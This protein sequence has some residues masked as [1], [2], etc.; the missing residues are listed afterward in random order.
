MLSWDR[1]VDDWRPAPEVVLEVVRRKREASGNETKKEDVV[2]IV[3]RI[4]H[5]I[6]ICAMF[7]VFTNGRPFVNLATRFHPLRDVAF[8]FI[9]EYLL[10]PLWKLSHT[11]SLSVT[12]QLGP[13]R[14]EG[15]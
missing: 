3:E 4:I 12:H 11:T 14:P 10:Y 15:V 7:S 13:C 9:S 1:M 2:A 5:L 6:G 8:T